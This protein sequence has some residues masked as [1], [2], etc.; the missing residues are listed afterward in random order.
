MIDIRVPGEPGNE[1][2]VISPMPFFF[3]LIVF[4]GCLATKKEYQEEGEEFRK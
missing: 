3:N 4:T 1:L 2:V